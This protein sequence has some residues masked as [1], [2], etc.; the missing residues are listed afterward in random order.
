MLSFYIYTLD[1]LPNDNVGEEPIF[2]SNYVSIPS[3]TGVDQ[4]PIIPRKNIT[5][6]SEL[7]QR[8]FGMVIK[9]EAKMLFLINHLY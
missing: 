7:G 4:L 6:I 5:C 2:N 8:N 9:G 3:V 1:K